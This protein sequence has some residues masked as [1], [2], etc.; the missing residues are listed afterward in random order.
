MIPPIATNAKIPAENAPSPKPPAPDHARRFK[1]ILQRQADPEP[2]SGQGQVAA[3]PQQQQSSKR[4]ET[5]ELAAAAIADAG[6]PVSPRSA[7]LTAGSG[8]ATTLGEAEKAAELSL[9][10]DHAHAKPA[11]TQLF[12][13]GPDAQVTQALL[14]KASAEGG[15]NIAL[16]PGASNLAMDAIEDLRRRLAA[17]G[18]A[19][20]RVHLRDGDELPD[21]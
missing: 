15:L 4:M 9:R 17:R 20:A 13:Q 10:L 16:V 18:L 6:Q 21:S 12:L 8:D 14:S 2:T 7:A 5:A 19:V 3:F 1:A 11:A